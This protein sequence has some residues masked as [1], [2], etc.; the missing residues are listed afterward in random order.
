MFWNS[1]SFIKRT[2]TLCLADFFANSL[3]P[4][5]TDK[6]FHYIKGLKVW[7]GQVFWP[8]YLVSTS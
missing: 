6:Y 8:D 7:S 2:L 3:D 4:D 1:I 5:Q